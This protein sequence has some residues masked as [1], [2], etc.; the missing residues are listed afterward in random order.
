MQRNKSWAAELKGHLHGS[1]LSSL[2]S[3]KRRPTQGR[4][5][6]GLKTLDHQFRPF[7]GLEALQGARAHSGSAETIPRTSPKKN[8]QK[9]IP[10]RRHPAGGPTRAPSLRFRQGL[11]TPSPWIPETRAPCVRH[12]LGTGRSEDFRAHSVVFVYRL[13]FK[14]SI[15]PTKDMGL[16]KWS[17]FVCS[18]RSP[19]SI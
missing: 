18:D 10:D 2:G 4:G 17:A 13:S 3:P 16:P 5:S 12:P 1:G 7:K 19:E 9:K 11:G 6:M 15:H 8:V 14:V